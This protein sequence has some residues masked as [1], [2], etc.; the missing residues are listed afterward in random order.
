MSAGR[1]RS[2][3]HRLLLAA[4]VALVGVVAV[5]AAAYTDVATLQLGTGATGSGLGN[6]HRFDIAVAD[7]ASQWQ[8]AV[9]A[10]SAV[11]LTPTSGTQFSESSPVVM[12]ATFLNRD[13][14]VAGDLTLRLWDP[15]DTGPTDLF[16]SL[17]FTVAIDGASTPAISGATAAAVNAAD[18]VI[19]DVAPGQQPRVTVSAVIAAGSG[20]AAAGKS[21]SIGVS[22]EGESR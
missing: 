5:T 16:A 3:R 19:P 20:I 11:T 7:S 14:G 15:D 2:G 21:T 17:L 1:P 13:P 12:D 6:P 18:I 8:D 4:G 22:A 10:A 9:T